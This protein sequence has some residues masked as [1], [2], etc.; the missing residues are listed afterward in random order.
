MSQCPLCPNL[1]QKVQKEVSQMANCNLPIAMLYRWFK[2]KLKP[3]KNHMWILLFILLFM[4]LLLLQIQMRK[5]HQN[6]IYNILLTC[7]SQ[8]VIQ[9]YTNIIIRI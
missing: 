9:T 3:P 2:C 1:S 4:T 7:M 6:G 5:T 8:F